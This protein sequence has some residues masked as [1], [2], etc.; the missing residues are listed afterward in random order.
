MSNYRS[1]AALADTEWTQ[2][3]R[4]GMA[5]LPRSLVVPRA[6]FR[7][8]VISLGIALQSRPQKEGRTTRRAGQG[9]PSV[10]N[11]VQWECV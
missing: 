7:S 10:H 1:D 2:E 6:E 4:D 5:D 3:I 9:Y 8:D 11:A